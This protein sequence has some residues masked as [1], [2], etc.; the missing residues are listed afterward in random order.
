MNPSPYENFLRTPLLVLVVRMKECEPFFQRLEST[1]LRDYKNP[2]L[3][4]K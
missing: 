2:L 1:D 3:L 4:F